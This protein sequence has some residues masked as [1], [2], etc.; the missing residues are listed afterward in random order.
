MEEIIIRSLQGRAS[1]RELEQ[2]ARWRASEP[3]NERAFVQLVRLWEETP[4][5]DHRD[6]RGPPPALDIIRIAHLRAGSHP[7]S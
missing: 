4:R 5:G 2:M 1:R 7:G 3:A 6:R